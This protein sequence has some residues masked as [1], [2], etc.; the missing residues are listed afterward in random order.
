MSI[1]PG[2]GEFDLIP[3]MNV[4]VERALM[5]GI[6]RKSSPDAAIPQHITT[7]VERALAGEEVEV[8]GISGS[9]AG[10]YSI[11]SD[12]QSL[13]AYFGG[14]WHILDNMKGQTP[15]DR[16]VPVPT[17]EHT[18][19]S[20][21]NQLATSGSVWTTITD[22]PTGRVY[23]Q[24]WN[25]LRDDHGQLPVIRR[26]TAPSW[27]IRT[28]NA[29]GR[30]QQEFIVLA[31]LEVPEFIDRTEAVLEE[32]K[33]LSRD[34]QN[35]VTMASNIPTP[36]ETMDYLDRKKNIG[37]NH[38]EHVL[39]GGPSPKKEL[40]T[41]ARTPTFVHT[42]SQL[43]EIVPEVRGLR[44]VNTGLVNTLAGEFR[45]RLPAAL[46]PQERS[47]AK[48]HERGI[49]EHYSIPAADHS[50]IIAPGSSIHFAGGP[51]LHVGLQG[52]QI[53][54]MASEMDAGIH[55]F[56]STREA[57]LEPSYRN[58]RTT[59]ASKVH[60]EAGVINLGSLVAKIR[61]FSRS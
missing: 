37:G 3:A 60:P 5:Q 18:R 38:W 54:I 47:R 57:Q 27:D 50:L 14:A 4:R 10:D 8:Y 34:P 48:E 36:R 53:W 16:T 15:P 22:K 45:R 29:Q 44:V 13:D 6:N 1:D 35:L 30:L 31:K 58:M 19:I 43:F 41:D 55:V 21:F 59:P 2:S 24:S 40:V 20:L 56:S 17:D 25:L 33:A 28:T 51:G 11:P 9:F 12:R 39:V 49:A 42:G 61:D 46:S 7:S 26:T 52:D 23:N 32:V